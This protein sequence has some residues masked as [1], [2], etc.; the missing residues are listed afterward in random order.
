MNRIFKITILRIS[1]RSH[2]RPLWSYRP[3][4]CHHQLPEP[5]LWLFQTSLTFMVTIFETSVILV[6]SKQIT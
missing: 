6:P 1:V 3:V 4:N 2:R 5:L